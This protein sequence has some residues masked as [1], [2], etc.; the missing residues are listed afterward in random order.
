MLPLNRREEVDVIAV[1]SLL[2]IVLAIMLAARIGA[3]AL[4]A[5]LTVSA[6]AGAFPL[7]AQDGPRVEALEWRHI[8]PFNGGRGTSV[9]GHPTATNPDLRLKSTALR[10]D[11]PIVSL[12]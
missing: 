8:G 12:Q 9:V 5:T 1:A 11:W 6:S 4:V 7:A 10:H 3:V 2:F